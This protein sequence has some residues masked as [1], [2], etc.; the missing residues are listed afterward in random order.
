VVG[1]VLDR[2]GFAITHEIFAGNTQDQ[3]TLATMLD[4]LGERVELK[5]GSTVVI[6]RGMAFDENIADIKQRKLH[7]VVASRQPERDRWLAEFDD[8]DGFIPVLRQ[9]SPLNPAQKK[10]SIEVKI[11]I[12][13]DEEK[14]DVLC[15]SEQRIGKDRPIRVKQQGRLLADIEKLAQRVATKSSSRPIKSTRQ[16]D[17]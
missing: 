9:P 17:D 2:D 12:G 10:T 4:R 5:P 11:C 6:D 14:T 16:S 7:Y 15:R 1:L 8:T 3:T 13:D